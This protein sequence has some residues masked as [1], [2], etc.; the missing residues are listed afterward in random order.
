MVEEKC[1]V[2]GGVKKVLG[3]VDEELGEGAVM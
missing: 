3:E 2:D 1:V